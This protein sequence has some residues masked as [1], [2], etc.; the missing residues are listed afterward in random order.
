MLSR[1][2]QP[3]SGFS[4]CVVLFSDNSV[5]VDDSIFSTVEGN[6]IEVSGLAGNAMAAIAFGGVGAFLM[7]GG[8]FIILKMFRKKKEC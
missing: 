3:N 2:V 4:T 7:F 6:D 5:T 8:I 1:L